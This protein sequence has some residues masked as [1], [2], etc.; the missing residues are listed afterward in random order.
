MFA[1]LGSTGWTI[2]SPH[3]IINTSNKGT[4]NDMRETMNQDSEAE[5]WAIHA[6][7]VFEMS[8]VCDPEYKELTSHLDE[9]LHWAMRETIIGYMYRIFP[10]FNEPR[11]R[12]HFTNAY[13]VRTKRMEYERKT[14][15]DLAKEKQAQERTNAVVKALYESGH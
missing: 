9:E 1:S 2:C 12:S 14:D 6:S 10:D 13:I 11:F 5:K 15:A 3:G 8:V 7:E 4:V